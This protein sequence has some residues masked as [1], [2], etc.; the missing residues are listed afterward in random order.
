M[1]RTYRLGNVL[2]EIYF[3]ETTSR[4]TGLLRFRGLVPRSPLP[5]PVHPRWARAEK[6]IP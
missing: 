3:P 6:E 4:K 1:G 5:T 2:A